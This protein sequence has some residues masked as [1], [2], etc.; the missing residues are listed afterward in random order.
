VP[1]ALAQ[2]HAAARRGPHH[3]GLIGE[4]EPAQQ[5]PIFIVEDDRPR[6]RP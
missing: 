1:R 5:N 2:L 4:L 6:R 3:H